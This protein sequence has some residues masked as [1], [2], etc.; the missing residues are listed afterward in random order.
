MSQNY[1]WSRVYVRHGQL[2]VDRYSW[3][4]PAP[5]S[6][7]AFTYPDSLELFHVVKK[8]EG[9]LR[10]R[11]VRT[12]EAQAVLDV[13]FA[14]DTLHPIDRQKLYGDCFYFHRDKLVLDNR[15]GQGAQALTVA[16]NPQHLGV[17][18]WWACPS[19]GRRKRLLYFFFVAANF[20]GYPSRG[21][22][23]CRTCLGLTYASRSRHKCA[24]QDAID[25]GRGNPGAIA[26][27][28][29]R[30]RKVQRNH[31]E[32]LAR[33]QRSNRKH[34][35]LLDDLKTAEQQHSTA[36]ESATRRHR[37]SKMSFKAKGQQ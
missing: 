8:S 21:A 24:E 2:A 9:S 33:M 23:A 14:I 7:I 12:N 20:Q 22:L 25:A 28:K 18:Y 27:V 15:P 3:L 35:S 36:I 6:S 17:R 34:L 26:R 31:D 32:L 5:P 16:S 29:S 10:T 37:Q 13:Q 4:R 1:D 19:C 11:A 30:R